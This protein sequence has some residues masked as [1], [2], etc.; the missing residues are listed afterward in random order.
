M[1]TLIWMQ[2]LCEKQSAK[3]VSAIKL[4]AL[5]GAGLACVCRDSVNKEVDMAKTN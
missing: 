3:P 5:A 1:S 2:G 4:T